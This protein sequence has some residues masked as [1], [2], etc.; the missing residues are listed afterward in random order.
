MTISHVP[1]ATQAS[2]TGSYTPSALFAWKCDLWSLT[3]D[4]SSSIW[5]A[6]G[7][8]PWPAAFILLSPGGSSP[9]PWLQNSVEGGGSVRADEGEKAGLEIL[10]LSQSVLCGI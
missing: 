8:F 5:V 1:P 9:A 4:P 3:A 2:L 6:E 7:L 10:G